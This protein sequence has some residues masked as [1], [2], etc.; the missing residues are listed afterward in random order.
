MGYAARRKREQR[1]LRREARNLGTGLE[2]LV[3]PSPTSGR[4][5]SFSTEI[6]A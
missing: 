3:A 2:L 6:S 5:Q 4:V 1:A